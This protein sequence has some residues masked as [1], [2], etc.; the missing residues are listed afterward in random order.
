MGAALSIVI[1]FTVSSTMVR[2]AGVFL[3]HT[4]IPRHVARLQAISALSG[5]GFTTSESELLLQTPERRQVLA[6]LIITG[7]I[8]LAS[9]VATLVA[10]VIGVSGTVEGL[11]AQIVAIVGSV[12]FVKYILFSPRVDNAVCAL[13][14]AWLARQPGRMQN[15]FVTIANLDHTMVLAEHTAKVEVTDD[16]LNQIDDIRILGFRAGHTSYS[17]QPWTGGSITPG[18]VLLVLAPETAQVAVAVILSKT[19]SDKVE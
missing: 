16:S 1:L 19:T 11:L 12:V 7:S 5:T 13:A 6:I 17:L 15:T 8:G 10:G 9:V 14:Y 18:Q 3:E 4:G 2:V